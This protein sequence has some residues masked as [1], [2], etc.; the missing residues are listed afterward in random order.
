MMK[1]NNSS[2]DVNVKAEISAGDLWSL[3]VVMSDGACSYFGKDI[4]EL[5]SDLTL[6]DFMDYVSSLPSKQVIQLRVTKPK[7][8]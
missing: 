3:L 7:K 2:S 6:S 8:K 4:D 1:D 5:M